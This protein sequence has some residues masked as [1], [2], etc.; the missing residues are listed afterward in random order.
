[1]IN[2][3]ICG[4]CLNIMSDMDDYFIDLTVTSP[5]Y[6]NL[7]SYNNDID[8]TWGEH[9]WKPIINELYRVTKDGGI[10]VW[11]VGDGTVKGSETGTSFKQALYA[12]EIG[13]NLHDTM[14]YEKPSSPYPM[15]NRYYQVFE[16]MFVWSKGK[17][18]TSNLLKDRKNKHAGDKVARK[19]HSRNVNGETVE[20][21][22]YRN[23][24]NRVI[25]PYGIRF[26]IWKM[27]TS[28][29]KGDKIAL[30]HPATFPED[31]ANDHILTWSNEGDLVFDPMCGSGTTLKMAKK[32]KRNYIGIDLS[33][34]YCDIARERL[35]NETSFTTFFK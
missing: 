25:K 20:N 24:K 22:A 4:D 28:S 5:P 15:H 30:K 29:S 10:V 12:M 11:I 32:N 27:T 17:P 35:R 13:F 14:I 21:S 23:D 34:E 31:L 7:R 33:E 9:V 16:Y 1:M 3:V 8:K 6:D 26:N 19:N 18:K 2:E